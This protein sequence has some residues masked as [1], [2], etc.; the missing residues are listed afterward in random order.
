MFTSKASEMRYAVVRDGVRPFTTA[1]MVDGLSPVSRESCFCEISLRASSTLSLDLPT[2]HASL[3]ALPAGLPGL[4]GFI[5]VCGGVQADEHR[6]PY[7]AAVGSIEGV[8]DFEIV[9]ECSFVWI[10]IFS[11]SDTFFSPN[12]RFSHLVV[13]HLLQASNDASDFRSNSVFMGSV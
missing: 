6:R 2:L 11:T 8:D 9:L 3:P 5:P 13:F 10:A 1:E 12:L 4:R 7:R